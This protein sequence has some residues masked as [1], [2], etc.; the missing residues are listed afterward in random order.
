LED[1]WG[2]REAAIMA[3]SSR[4]APGP[5]FMCYR[6]EDTGWPA[7]R[8]YDAL[9]ER[10]QVFRDVESIRPGE[11]F[12]AKI[13][14]AVESC[15]VLLALIGK[16]WLT[17]TDGGTSRR[18]DNPNDH[19]RLELEAALARNSGI[20]PI[21][22]D[23]A[24]M[25]SAD[26][27]PPSLAELTSRNG[28]DLDQGRFRSDLSR[29]VDVIG[30]IIS[31][32]RRWI[33]LYDSRSSGFSLSDF[34]TDFWEGAAGELV[35]Q[36]ADDDTLV[37]DR[38]NTNG[39]VVAWLKKYDYID[40]PTVIPL[41]DAAGMRRMFRVRCEVQAHDAEHTFLLMFKLDGAPPGQF[42][43]VRR[44]RITPGTWNHIDEHFDVWLSANCL[45]R[46]EDRDVSAAPSRIKIR[47]LIVT[48]REPPLRLIPVTPS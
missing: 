47:D 11:D 28:L 25:P 12:V 37:I 3:E 10:F 41:G 8:L 21:L 43:D 32:A 13:N 46:L 42:L 29:L 33:T 40:G 18:I 24:R 22:V 9:T 36:E 5:I 31:G 30:T 48:E 19:V 34:H 45:L 23:G 14:A 7:G 1:G 6:R 35:T 39:T 27:L 38:G 2:K 15:D 44:H 17:I 4:A 26:D 16:E 20:I